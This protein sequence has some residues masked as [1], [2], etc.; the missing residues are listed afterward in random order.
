M[1]EKL[2]QRLIDNYNITLANMEKRDIAALELGFVNDN[3]STMIFSILIHCMEN[4]EIFNST[5]LNNISNFINK[6]N[7]VG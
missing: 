3:C 2:R 1:E 4:L 7:Y 6:I 5:Q